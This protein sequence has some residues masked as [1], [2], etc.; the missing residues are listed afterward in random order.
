MLSFVSAHGCLF[1]LIT[2]VTYS[3][4]YKEEHELK[5]VGFERVETYVSLLQTKPST[6]HFKLADDLT[7]SYIF[8]NYLTVSCPVSGLY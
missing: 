6:G 1:N 7:Y 5:E 4:R 2:I 8:S 3:S